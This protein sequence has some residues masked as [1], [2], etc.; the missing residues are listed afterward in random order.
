MRTSAQLTEEELLS[1]NSLWTA[2]LALAALWATGIECLAGEIAI[3]QAGGRGARVV[4]ASRD[5]TMQR[6]GGWL[7]G[8][9]AGRGYPVEPSLATEM[10]EDGP[11]V[12]VLETR[13]ACPSARSLGVNTSFLEKARADAYVLRVSKQ[14]GRPVVAVVGRTSQGVRS[15]VAR[16][17]AL[18]S[19]RDGKLLAPE[20]QE[21]RTPFFPIR[22]L[23]VC[24]TG[25]IAQG[26]DWCAAQGLPTDR[27]WAD[28]LWTTWTDDR[29]K[30]YAEQLWLLG[31]NSVEV[32]E[33]RGYRGVF[34]D[35]DLAKSITPKLI[36]F[37]KALRENGLQVSQFIWGQ[38]LFV[39][40]ENLCWNSPDERKTME[41]EFRR[42]AETYG[43]YVDHI[44]VHVGDPGGCT[45]NG[46]DAYATTQQ[47][48]T[49]LLNEYRKVNP[50]VTAT[51]STWANEGFLK[52]SPNTKF[53]DETYSPKELSIALHRWY[54]VL[55]CD[56]ISGAGRECDIWGWY[57][58]DYELALDMGL[59][60]RRLD[61]YY[62]SLPRAASRKVRA[63][64]TEINFSG[65]PQ[66][67]NA[68]VSGQKMWS[69][70]RKLADI[71][72]EFCAGVFGDKNAEAMVAIYQ[73][74]ESYVHPDR[75]LWFIPSTDCLPEVFGTPEY[76]R[77]LRKALALAR[78][79][80]IG[81]TPRLTTATDPQAL[82]DYLVRNLNVISVFSEAQEKLDLARESGADQAALQAIVDKARED[83][84]PFGIDPDYPGLL[85]QLRQ[86]AAQDAPAK[87]RD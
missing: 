81:G 39:E 10:G 59:F 54:D 72:R 87:W 23:H 49:F 74:C 29:L 47:I 37:M 70:Q 2:C 31:F 21:E 62:S 61:H 16:L 51:L 67:I 77:Q 20:T 9:L 13:D 14:R 69:P 8:F 84:L 63:I 18:M 85:E 25:R 34:S 12:W 82:F 79:V 76:N 65:W 36:V 86:S 32:A 58:S 48:A 6:T 44:V 68:Y 83:A 71:E 43:R 3:A 53:L 19:E 57:L 64:S 55:K 66:I 52:G 42:L 40:G 17:V 56:M 7:R 60:M 4:V 45:R 35:E 73:A 1:V 24:P 75:Y 46:C 78:K 22:R 38:S 15:G 41:K 26:N 11:P 5:A 28:T 50:N 33:I 30:T 27:T 80:E